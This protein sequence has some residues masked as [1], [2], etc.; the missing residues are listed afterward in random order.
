MRRFVAVAVFV[1]ATALLA[2]AGDKT[3][4]GTVID[5]G[6][7]GVFVQGKRVATEKFEIV[8][9]PEMNVATLELITDLAKGKPSQQ[10]ELQ[11]APN[12]D[13]VRYTWKDLSDTKAQATVEQN[14]EFLVEHATPTPQSKTEETPFLMP[15]STAVL[16][17]Y[18]FT[19][20]EIL[21]WRYLATGCMTN[22]DGKTECK[23]A[24]TSFSVLIPQQRTTM[25]VSLEFAG[26][27]KVTIRGVEHE[28]TRLN[29]VG[30]DFEWALWLDDNNHLVRI[31][32]ANQ[33]TEILRD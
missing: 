15:H 5:S 29:M 33:A 4:K 10:S 2:G 24:K 8:Q 32:V 27:E 11:L 20:R 19:H 22:A 25:Q 9:R 21:A 7:F 31:L 28:L 1:C 26:R 14:S 17:D 23:L 30:E 13:L 18:A 16:D 6:A 3:I 12:G